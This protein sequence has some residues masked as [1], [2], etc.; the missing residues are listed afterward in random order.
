MVTSL[1]YLGQVILVADNNLTVVEKN[2]S[3]ASKVWSRMS[4]I[5]GREGVAPQ[6]SGF[7]FKAMVQEVLIFRAETWV[8]IPRMGNSMGGVQTQVERRLTVLLLRRTPYGSWR[9]TSAAAARDEAVFL[10]ME[11]YISRRYNT[12][13]Q[14]IATRSLLDLCE[15]SERDPGA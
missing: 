15:G 9:Y 12:V 13:A 1:N 4:C 14:Y 6:V 5:L 11:E 3:R 7:F 10:N 2:L 8:V